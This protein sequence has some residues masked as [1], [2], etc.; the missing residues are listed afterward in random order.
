MDNT[1]YLSNTS[2][3]E[4]NDFSGKSIPDDEEIGRAEGVCVND[5]A[6]ITKHEPL[7]ASHGAR[8]MAREVGVSFF[9]F[10]S[11]YIN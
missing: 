1:W 5:L 7:Y 9:T 6:A 10:I 11:I 8:I 3:E 2:T 4:L